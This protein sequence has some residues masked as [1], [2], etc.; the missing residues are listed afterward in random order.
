MTTSATPQPP[1]FRQGPREFCAIPETVLRIPTPGPHPDK[2]ELRLE[3]VLIPLSV[4][5]VGALI[6]INFLNSGPYVFVGI[7]MA[8]GGAIVTFAGFIRQR[9][10]FNKKVALRQV[11]FEELL[12][13]REATAIALRTKTQACLMK[14]DPDIAGCKAL[15]LSRDP[16]RLWSRIANDRDFLCARLGL[17]ALPFQVKFELPTQMNALIK[18]PY[19]EKAE[20]LVARFQTVPD[21]PVLLDLHAAGV[22]G[23]AGE[24]KSTT[25]AARA[26]A[27]QLATHHSPEILRLAAVFPGVEAGQWT[28]MRWLPH[29]WRPDRQLRYLASD[30]ATAHIMLDDLAGILRQR[31]NQLQTRQHVTG[32]P[33]WPVS[34]VVF[35]ADPAALNP[36]TRRLLTERGPQLGFHAVFLAGREAELPR[37]CGAV[38]TTSPQP[39]LDLRYSH[40]ETIEYVPDLVT[41]EIADEISRLLAPLRFESSSGAI[42][43]LVGLFELLSLNRVEDWDTVSQWARNDSTKS[44]RIPIGIGAGGRKVVFDI[45]DDGHGPHGLAAGTSGSGKTRFLECLVAILAAHYH[46]HELAFMLIDFKGS[47]FLQDLPELPHCISVLSS[48]EGKSEDEQSWHATRALK[49]LQAESKRRQRLFAD[50]GVG[51]ISE[52][53]ER[54]RK[55]PKGLK[56]VPRLI[57]IVDEFAELASQQPDFL[58]GLVSLARIGRSLGMHLILSTQQPSGVVT[59]QIWANSRFRLSMKFNKTEDS[60]AVLKRPDA[61]YI[62]QRGRGYLQVGENEVFELFQGPYGGIP[63][64]EVDPA[65]LAR[66]RELEVIQIALNGER[67]LHLKKEK[68]KPAQTQL[69][70]LVQH[71]RN[72]AEAE[73]IEPVPD[74]LP[75]DAGNLVALT[76]IRKEQGWNG[77]G[78]TRTEAWLQPTIGVLDDPSGQLADRFEG[79]PLLRPDL[80]RFN[81]LFIC[82]DIADNTRLPLRTIIT[83]LVL[84]HSPAEM[85]IYALD[86]GNNVMGVFK[87]LPHLGATIRVTESRR[88]TRLFRWLFTELEQRREILASHGLT[89]AQARRRG[90]DLGRPA[91]VLVVDN[92][93]KWKDEADRKDELAAL[94][95]EGAQNGIHLILAGEAR[96]AVI[97]SSVLSSISPRLALGF[98]DKKAFRDIIESMPYDQ[99]VLGGFPEQGI[100]YDM[101]MGAI[102]CRVVAPV[103]HGAPDEREKNL[104]AIAHEMR[105]AAE[106]EGFPRPFSIGELPPE[107][108]LATIMPGDIRQTWRDWH[109]HPRLR[110]PIGLDDLK[111]E[112]LEVDLQD[113][114][115]HFL[116]IGPPRGGKTVALHSWLLSLAARVPPEGMHLVLF[117]NLRH[118]LTP[119]RDLPH[120]R[121]FV[122]TREETTSLF[123][124]LQQRLEDRSTTLEPPVVLAF[125]DLIQFDDSALRSELA[126]LV[127]Q[128]ASR[129]LYVLAAGRT[130]DMQKWADLEKALLKYRSGLL[131][132]SK[133][134]E[135]ETTFFDVILPM[136][137]GREKLPP[138]RGYLVRQGEPYMLQVARPGGTDAVREYVLQIVE[139][140][141]GRES[142]APLTKG[143][144]EATNADST[145]VT[146]TTEMAD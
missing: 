59:D 131:V 85:N 84:D 75:E 98:A 47:D 57:I 9:S 97:F 111:L 17:G 120:V 144:D 119:L 110:A 56:P 1:K 61:A 123:K 26:I 54:R 62:E 4:M 49:A 13:D 146:A 129:G 69:K 86:F 142:E 50:V 41:V 114:G 125:D 14:N 80:E 145:M 93:I 64:E 127:I 141:A 39:M 77:A 38:I 71:I 105:L 138:G 46:P 106:R 133:T 82:C 140:S 44:L 10:E 25:A 70:A 83:S 19:E 52:Y 65:L 107:M 102:E 34:Y 32:T 22:C 113:D 29:V 115:P 126:R 51:K 99:N 55:S 96:A 135:T 143:L 40:G 66:D 31:D 72:A 2:P 67:V 76:D 12:A 117:D 28:W 81:H 95:N 30:H 88:I 20:E 8:V 116:I 104:G 5:I 139:A 124:E 58:A 91:I 63:Y 90:I 21:V 16:T 87:E 101:D 78:W 109:I 35:I 36:E 11:K 53:H 74:L 134:V 118:T 130:A 48:I 132:G 18:D 92:L 45:H 24:H 112:P 89:W 100:Y 121:K 122:S 7:L 68:P 33:G 108:P 6:A 27:V 136:G 79:I 137:L 42:P 43:N 103:R 37:E 60:Q 128:G 73:G 94:V 3:G 15:A 23:I